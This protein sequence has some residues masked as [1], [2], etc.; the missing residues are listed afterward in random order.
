MYSELYMLVQGWQFLFSEFLI[1]LLP[2]VGGS[3]TGW[4]PGVLIQ[5]SGEGVQL[6]H[7][8]VALRFS[9]DRETNQQNKYNW[10]RRPD[11]PLLCLCL[12]GEGGW[13][14]LWLLSLPADCGPGTSHQ[15]RPRVLWWWDSALQRA[16]RH[17]AEGDWRGREEPGEI[18][19]WLPAAG[20]RPADP[21]ERVGPVSSHHREWRQQVGS[22]WAEPMG[23]ETLTCSMFFHVQVPGCRE[24]VRKVSVSCS[25]VSDSLWPALDCS[26]PG[27]KN[28]TLFTHLFILQAANIYEASTMYQGLL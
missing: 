19:L 2:W 24:C 10:V 16:D 26:L 20:G 6:S 1:F 27:K 14:F 18:I 11:S 28:H 7:P 5:A 4:F 23:T 17:P 13:V 12:Q 21:E 9:A 3:A 8:S 25:V 22:G 15:R